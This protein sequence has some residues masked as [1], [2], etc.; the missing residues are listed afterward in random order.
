MF[1]Y[2][3]T[4]DLVVKDNTNKAKIAKFINVSI[5]LDNNRSVNQEI[6]CVIENIF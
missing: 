2:Y 3:G 5:D 6:L 4:N 1:A